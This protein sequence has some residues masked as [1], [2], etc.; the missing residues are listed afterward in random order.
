[1]RTIKL[2]SLLLF[3]G[4]FFIACSD[5]DTA[6][7][8]DPDTQVDPDPDPDPDPDMDPDVDSAIMIGYRVNTP[9]GAVRYF[10][11]HEEFP[12]TINPSE[13]IE[14]GLSSRV[15]S[16]GEHPYTYNE[17][18]GTMTKWNVDRST[19]EISVGGIVSFASSGFS[20][21]AG[22]PPI[23][24]SET[25][26]FVSNLREGVVLEWNPSTMEITEVLNVDPLPNLG[27]QYQSVTG[28]YG[29]WNKYITSNGKVVMAVE[30]Y[31]PEACCDEGC[32]AQPGGAIVAVFDPVSGTIQY[33]Q[34]DRLYSTHD[35]LLYDPVTDNYYAPPADGN[36]HTFQYF[37]EDLV[38]N[39]FALLRLNDDGSFDPDF[40]LNLPD[41]IDFNFFIDADFIFD[42]KLVF[43]YIE[44]L[45]F[46][47]AYNERWSW[48]GSVPT[49]TAVL[50][51]NTGEVTPFGGF[52]QY[53][54]ATY[55]NNNGG[56]NFF[57]AFNGSGEGG[58][59]RQ[60][61]FDAF[62]TVTTMENG[63]FRWVSTLWGE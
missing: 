61:G 49:S 19:L 13:A 28:F 6:P 60:D 34:D 20:G 39:P 48:F 46:P 30:H 23:F 47:L 50:D 37:G 41:N 35:D 1:M 43:T 10:E 29:E 63:R 31:G 51:I 42:N 52:G 5:D 45:D 2:S 33:N 62:T 24:V 32:L 57:E 21:F 54:F 36:S 22:G 56:T 16:F 15:Y 27:E 53:S 40:A 25:Q 26:A 17:N 18:A 8:P 38:N 7:A 14:I 4:L 58:L 59:L 12:S 3:M 44:N 11:V 9:Q 55:I